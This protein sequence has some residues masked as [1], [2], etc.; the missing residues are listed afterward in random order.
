MGVVVSLF[1]MAQHRK[2]RSDF[3]L[4]DQIAKN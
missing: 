4:V 3:H 1:R 2:F